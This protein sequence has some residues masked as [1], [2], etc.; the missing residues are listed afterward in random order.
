M[1]DN[2]SK[3]LARALIQCGFKESPLEDAYVVVI[4][5][6]SVREKPEKKLFSAIGRVKTA[7]R[8]LDGG[9]IAV[10][11][12]VASQL[13][14]RIMERCPEVR[15]VVGGDGLT[16]APEAIERLCADKKLKLCLTDFLPEYPERDHFLEQ[17]PAQPIAYVNIMQGCDNFCAY[18]IVPFTRGRAKSRSPEAVLAECRALVAGGTREICLLGQ[19]VNAYGLD[20]SGVGL[21]FAGL[22]RRVS[23][24]PGLLR[25]RFMTPHPK[26]FSPEVVQL[27]GELDNLC[28]RLHLPL[29]SGSNVILEHMGRKYTAEKYLSLVADLRRARP[30]MAFSSDVIVGFPGESERDFQDTCRVVEEAGL[31]SSFSFCYSD[32]PGTRAS[33]LPDKISPET[34][35]DRL[36]RFQ[37]MQNSLSDAWL[38]AQEGRGECQILLEGPSRKNSGKQWQGRDI[39]GIPVNIMLKHGEGAAGM[40]LSATITEARKHSLI[41]IQ[42]GVS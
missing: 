2:D 11:G 37:D 20:S 10:A 8:G 18:C 30:D 5:T 3:W 17:A 36:A 13:G 15:L 26:D 16:M 24:I 38:K 9:F 14:A 21:G 41:G 40:V 27:F 31:M 19:N 33:S 1:N 28:P 29:Q 34:Q 4:N 22:L 6:C 12:C 25:L 42:A 35:L 39:Y 7:Q 32:R 23:A